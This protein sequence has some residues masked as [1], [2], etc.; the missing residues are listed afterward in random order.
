MRVGFAVGVDVSSATDVRFI[1]KVT[2]A[3]WVAGG[4]PSVSTAVALSGRVGDGVAVV[5]ALAV[6]SGVRVGNGVHVGDGL[7]VAVGV[8][9]DVAVGGKS[10][11][12]VGV[13]VGR[14]VG[15][16]FSARASC[17]VGWGIGGDAL[18]S[19]SSNITNAII[20]TLKMSK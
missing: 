16:G 1:L 10:G 5:V 15:V 3:I 7:T 14:L 20:I 6:G 4:S 2:S 8:R 12:T 19:S 18:P 17:R 13:K 11:V 9:V